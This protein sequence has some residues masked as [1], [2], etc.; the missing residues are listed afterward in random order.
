MELWGRLDSRNGA[1]RELWSRS[2]D[3]RLR[4][5]SQRRRVRK[6]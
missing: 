3:Q 1:S 5:C 4:E 6:Q 2:V